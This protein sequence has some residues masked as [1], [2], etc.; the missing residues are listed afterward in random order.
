VS[1]VWRATGNFPYKW[2]GSQNHNRQVFI[3]DNCGYET[4]RHSAP[5]DDEKM[6][7]QREPNG[8]VY[9]VCEDIIVLK[10][11]DS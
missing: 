6:H 2:D 5:A 8:T 4:H 7:M 9:L 1:H 11:M 3:C 10:V